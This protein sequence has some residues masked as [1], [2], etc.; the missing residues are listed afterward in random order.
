MEVNVF[1][2]MLSLRLRLALP[3]LLL[4]NYLLLTQ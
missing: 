3:V 4:L 1:S 2:L